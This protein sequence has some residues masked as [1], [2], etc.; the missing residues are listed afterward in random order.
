MASTP[1]GFV[2][3]LFESKDGRITALG[4]TEVTSQLLREVLQ[5][6]TQKETPV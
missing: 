5:A 2:V 4:A 1:S 6:L 3:Q